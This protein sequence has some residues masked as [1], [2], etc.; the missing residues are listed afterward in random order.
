LTSAALPAKDDVVRQLLD[1]GNVMLHLDPRS[2]AVLVPPQFKHNEQLVL[3]IGR[4][5]RI[6]IP[7]LAVKGHE[8]SCTLSFSG[9]PHLCRIPWA[10]V[11]AVVGKDK[12]GMVWPDDV[13]PELRDAGSVNRGQRATPTSPPRAPRNPSLDRTEALAVAATLDPSAVLSPTE[14]DE[15]H[16]EW[17]WRALSRVPK[18]VLAGVVV[19]MAIALRPV[20]E[21]PVALAGAWLGKQHWIWVGSPPLP[22]LCFLLVEL[23]LLPYLLGSARPHRNDVLFRAWVGEY[24]YFDRW[25]PWLER[26]AKPFIGNAGMRP[27]LVVAWFIGSMLDGALLLVIV[28]VGTRGQP[29][30]FSAP[31]L[32]MVLLLGVVLFKVFAFTV[33][34][35]VTDRLAR[36][37]VRDSGSSSLGAAN[38]AIAWPEIAAHA[39][40]ADLIFHA[41]IVILAAMLRPHHPLLLVGTTALMGTR[42][43]VPALALGL[44]TLIALRASP[45]AERIL[46]D[47]AAKLARGAAEVRLGAAEQLARMPEAW[48]HAGAAAE[49]T[50]A[51]ADEEPTVRRLAARALGPRAPLFRSFEFLAGLSVGATW[52]DFEAVLGPP[53]QRDK[54]YV[55]YAGRD[56]G[57]E[58]T[59]G[60][61]RSGGVT[62]YDI[63]LR[64][65]ASARSVAGLREAGIEHPALALLNLNLEVVLA[66]LGLPRFGRAGRLVYPLDTRA[67]QAKVA[68]NFDDRTQR[69]FWIEVTWT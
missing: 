57:S 19:L 54:H 2:D 66:N 43:L 13:P 31:D 28:G 50:K 18:L 53:T 7:D 60:L 35:K 67:E 58:L 41:P 69:C 30:P 25:A 17:W 27:R 68:L 26:L 9:K 14:R 56:G 46:G 23:A 38:G 6:P 39:A 5:M 29:S 21:W 44:L 47:L 22:F 64:G 48:K 65:S 52:R 51:L 24:S 33:V 8:L 4:N 11:F 16:G 15:L 3:E 62:R 10:A 40:A 1:D 32:S 59:L 36:R 61:D 20:F 37:A 12:R 63:Q 34:L 42:V 55:S 49:L 45:S